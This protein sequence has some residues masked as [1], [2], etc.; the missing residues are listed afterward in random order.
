M[1][2]IRKQPV[3][4]FVLI[5]I[6]FSSC[7]KVLETTPELYIDQAQSIVDKRSA[8]AALT[9]AYNAL[10]LNSYQGNAFRYVTNLAGDNIKWVGNSPTNREF[11]VYGIFTTNSRV[12]EL[13]SAIYKTINISNNIIELVPQVTDVTLSQADRNK[14]RG[15]AFFLRALGYFDL[16]RLWANVPITSAATQTPGDA[17]GVKNSRSDEIY[18][19]IEK[20]LD[21]AEKL[22]PAIVNRNR[23]NQ[24]TV[25]ALKARLYLYLE[26]WPKAEKYATEV[27]DNSTD[28]RLVKPYSRFYE[29]KNT[30]ES[31]FELDYTI[32]NK[33]NYA[34]NWF[35]N[36]VS[37]GKKEFLPTDEFITMVKDP[38]IGGSRSALVFTAGGITYGNMN[39]KI[40]TGEDQ[41]YILRLAEI[42][43][44]RAE[45]RAEQQKLAEGLQDL[46]VIRTRADVPAVQ[47][48]T[49]KEELIE[50]ILLER[51]ME[52]AYESH[53][54]FDIIRRGL[55]QKVLGITDANKLI[56]PIPRQEILVNPELTQNAGF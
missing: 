55:A 43:L 1:K 54:W 32:N 29:S 25:K 45:A 4:L 26:N 53:R 40:A 52:L 20:D 30:V 23:A 2:I 47:S 51:R 21:S 42:F 35:Q 7:K 10:S 17:K 39:F 12:Q 3:F 56:F 24:Y 28:F 37:G 16:V 6:L 22:L 48:V 46:N 19:F 18:R 15:E 5:A 38:A 41:V 13:W 8:Q 44:V 9:G 33:N 14:L 50:K 49:G 36:P 31:I 27:I 11:D 34:A